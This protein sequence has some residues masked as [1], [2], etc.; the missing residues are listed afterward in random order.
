METVIDFTYNHA[1]VLTKYL[2]ESWM[3]I[4]MQRVR[5][6]VKRRLHP[7]VS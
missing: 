7:L 3:I 4:A 5:R 1:S 2:S 6:A